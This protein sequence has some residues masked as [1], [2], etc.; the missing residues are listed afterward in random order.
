MSG[1][2]RVRHR[3]IAIGFRRIAGITLFVVFGLPTLWLAWPV[4]LGGSTGWTVVVG[5]PIHPDGNL[6]RHVPIRFGDLDAV[7]DVVVYRIP[8]GSAGEGVMVIHRITGGSD[9]E[10]F[11]TTGDNRKY[12]DPWRPGSG[13]IIGKHWRTVPGGGIV[14][15]WM[16]APIVVAGAMAISVFLLALDL[17]AAARAHRPRHATP[18]FALHHI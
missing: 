16:R 1:W 11:I 14:I 4:S 12:N 10:G 6:V 7:G 9:A 2:R 5:T 8:D 3:V 15:A 13:E 18:R 17:E